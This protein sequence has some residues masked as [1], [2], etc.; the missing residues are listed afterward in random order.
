MFEKC[1]IMSQITSLNDLSAMSGQTIWLVSHLTVTRYR[2]DLESHGFT[3]VKHS[4]AHMFS[5]IVGDLRC[6]KPDNSGLHAL[7][8]YRDVYCFH[9]VKETDQ[10][11]RAF[12][13]LKYLP[14]EGG[15]DMS[16]MFTDLDDAK[17]RAALIAMSNTESGAC[18][19]NP[20]VDS[21]LNL[22]CHIIETISFD[23]FMKKF[24]FRDLGP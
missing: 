15:E 14:D 13:Y 4:I 5:W 12:Q 3:P 20:N 7:R 24:S 6:E 8:Q 22:R 1:V 23:N 21:A 19:Y 10:R 16:G 11:Y 9:Q 2:N 17:T 18:S